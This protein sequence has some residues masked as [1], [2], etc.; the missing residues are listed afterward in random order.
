VENGASS[1]HEAIKTTAA[2]TTTTKT[3]QNK[4]KNKNPYITSLIP[5]FIIVE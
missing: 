1:A 3:K 2:A 4:N 5:V